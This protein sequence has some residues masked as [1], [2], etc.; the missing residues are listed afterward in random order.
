MKT[1]VISLITGVVILGAAVI[2]I[3]FV[4]FDRSQ[5]SQQNKG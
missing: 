1:G 5:M 4:F 3:V 2:N